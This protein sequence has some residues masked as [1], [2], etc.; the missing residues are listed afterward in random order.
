MS[1]IQPSVFL[2]SYHGGVF[3]VVTLALLSPVSSV[4]EVHG[5][6]CLGHVNQTVLESGICREDKNSRGG[7]QRTLRV[8]KTFS[9]PSSLHLSSNVVHNNFNGLSL[10]FL[11]LFFFFL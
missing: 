8:K 2:C 3:L 10:S 6:S 11:S 5:D 9:F 1:E 7:D 4:Q